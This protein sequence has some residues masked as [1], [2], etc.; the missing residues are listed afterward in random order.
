MNKSSPLNPKQL[1]VC[2]TVLTRAA[3]KTIGEGIAFEQLKNESARDASLH[4]LQ[5]IETKRRRL[6]LLLQ[7]LQP[8]NQAEWQAQAAEW[9]L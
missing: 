9:L 1:E 8:R 6:E 3:T 4:R 5:R 7:A 2:I